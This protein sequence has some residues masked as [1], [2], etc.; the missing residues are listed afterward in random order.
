[1]Y[2]IQNIGK[3]FSR[4]VVKIHDLA[5]RVWEFLVNA[6]PWQHLLLSNFFLLFSNLIENKVVFIVVLFYIF[7]N[8]WHWTSLYVYWPF[9]FILMWIAYTY[10]TFILYFAI[11]PFRT[12]L[13]VSSLP[14]LFFFFML[15]ISSL[16]FL[17]L[18]EFRLYFCSLLFKKKVF[19]FCTNIFIILC[20]I[21]AFWA[22]FK[23]SF[24]ILRSLSQSF[25]YFLL[26]NLQFYFI[27][28][29]I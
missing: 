18:F 11:L 12:D 3:P 8:A 22:W 7:L 16:V 28:Y 27:L 25:S 14:I 19:Y 2:Y 4:V 9:H 13:Y 24:T 1:M 10:P 21:F 15:E 20:I 26:I 29:V 17:L 5:S 23:K 6:Y